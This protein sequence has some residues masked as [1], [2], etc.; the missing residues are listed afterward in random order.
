MSTPDSSEQ[1]PYGNGYQQQGQ[2]N[3][4]DNYLPPQQPPYP[5]PWPNDLYTYQLQYVNM[6][7]SSEQPYRPSSSSTTPKGKLGESD[8]V[9][10]E[11][12]LQV[13]N[14]SYLLL[15]MCTRLNVGTYQHIFQLCRIEG[16]NYSLRA[17][18]VIFPFTSLSLYTW[19]RLQWSLLWVLMFT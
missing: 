6:Y 17:A 12:P 1:Q 2:S 9:S 7:G 13:S 4:P 14:W 19:L 5:P 11:H 3:G 18:F 10:E 8:D 15:Q 16:T